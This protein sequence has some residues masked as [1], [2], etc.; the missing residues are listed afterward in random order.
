MC[1]SNFLHY[2]LIIFVKI[3]HSQQNKFGNIKIITESLHYQFHSGGFKF[4]KEEVRDWLKD[5]LA[6]NLK[7]VFWQIGK[8]VPIPDSEFTEEYKLIKYGSN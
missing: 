6:T 2:N 4:Y 5:P 3:I 7:S 8:P 1:F